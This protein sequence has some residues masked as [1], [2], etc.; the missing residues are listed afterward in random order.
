MNLK[1]SFLHRLE[2]H[3]ILVFL[4]LFAFA[5]IIRFHSFIPITL[6]RDEATYA[7]F[8]DHLIHGAEL[9][10]DVQDIKPPGIFIIYAGIQLIVGKSLIAIRLMS[11]LVVSSAAFFLFL[12][13][14]NLGLNLIPSLLTAIIYILMF[15][16]FFGLS[17]NTELYFIWC[18]ALGLLQFQ[19]AK[20]IFG[21]LLSGLIIGVGFTIKQHA[22]FDFAALGLFFLI[23][24]LKRRLF[25][26]NFLSMA[27]MVI[28]FAL[29]YA[30]VH[31]YFVWNGNWEYYH[32]VTYVAPTNYA[33]KHNIVNMIRFNLTALLM[34]SPFFAMGAL[35]FMHKDVDAKFKLLIVLLL[36][37]DIIAINLT[38]K[39]FKHYLLQLA[40][41]VSLIAGEAYRVSFFKHLFHRPVFQKA[42]FVLVIFYTVVLG[43]VYHNYRFDSA[44]E[45]VA[46]FDGR[47]KAEDTL[48]AADS[49]AILYWYYDKKSPTKYI[50]PTLTVFPHHIQE[51]GIDIKSELN[52]ILDNEPT[53][54]VL[55]DRYPHD[56][57]IRRVQSA[58]QL[59][60]DLEK[61][62]VY[63]IK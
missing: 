57:F 13:K 30:L 7:V 21:Y 34:Y 38:G 42:A 20:G 50:H 18:F 11:I 22:A 24:S 2:S 44:R 26:K 54:V 40:I 1:S 37:F 55:S 14:R 25:W 28:G 8:A 52:Q 9:Y 19:K 35:A 51:L 61:Y 58:Y 62:S 47:I 12:F 29:P 43:V 16:Y 10:K 36:C 23:S 4:C 17:G 39:S 41:P 49:P 56:W 46:F 33:A 53:Y 31:L 45:L 6:D 3:N 63:K 27:M 15:N 59:M 48:F 60:G 5:L 32:Y